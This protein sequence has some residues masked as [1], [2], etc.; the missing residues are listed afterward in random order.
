MQSDL[1]VCVLQD[2]DGGPVDGAKEEVK[3]D[4][5]GAGASKGK[6]ARKVNEK[7]SESKAK[8]VAKGASEAKDKQTATAAKAAPAAA[9]ATADKTDKADSAADKDK[10]LRK[11]N[12]LLRQ[13][14]Q[15]EISA[16]SG[17]ALSAEEQAKINR[18]EATLAE[19]KALS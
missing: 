11:L 8:D 2:G 3:T 9:N 10:Q 13:I 16:K 7:Q 12:K 4:K 15:L 17:A 5:T 19:I 1:C 6:D 14:E 18:K